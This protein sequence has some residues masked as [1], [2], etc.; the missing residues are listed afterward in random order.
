MKTSAFNDHFMIPFERDR[1]DLVL[2]CAGKGN[3]QEFQRREAA[4]RIKYG[5]SLTPENEHAV[6]AGIRSQQ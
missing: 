2:E 5:L 1:T 4:L 6:L 3:P